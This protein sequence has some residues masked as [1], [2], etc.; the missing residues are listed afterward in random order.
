MYTA[1]RYVFLG[2]LEYDTTDAAYPPTLTMQISNRTKAVKPPL[3]DPIAPESAH[4][5][6]STAVLGYTY[7]L[8]TKNW[9][10]SNAHMAAVFCW[11]GNTNRHSKIST[12]KDPDYINIHVKKI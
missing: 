9:L 11:N 3:G 2:V 7:P 5:H 10:I 12:T 8:P 1:N 6:S 4:Q